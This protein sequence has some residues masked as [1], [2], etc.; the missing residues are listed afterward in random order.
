MT[1]LDALE[2]AKKLHAQRSREAARVD[3]R[4]VTA[5]TAP[6]APARRRRLEVASTP[7]VALSF[8]QLSIDPAVCL[9]HRVLLS[10]PQGTAHARA[11]DSYRI[12]RTRLRHRLSSDQFVTLGIVSAGPDEGKS[13]T[14]IN[15]ALAFA[16]EKR[17]NV[18]LLDLDLRNPSL[19]RYLGVSPAVDLSNCLA[20]AAK[21]E[22][23]FFSV[24]IE[25]LVL[26]GGL[27]SH[28]NSSELLGNT[29]LL[30]LL[31]YIKSMDPNALVI[32]DLPPL[33]QSA[34]SMVVAPHL[35][36]LALVISEGVTRRE[37]LSR[38]SELLSSLNV[39]GV[40]VNRSSEAI[41]D[42]YG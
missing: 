25:H 19:C 8:P 14:A 13:V 35:T 3:A 38:A 12:L 33:L 10:A 27:S 16:N 34:D 11:I 26:A 9:S 42:Y 41:E 15:L 18:F 20:R 36:T 21:P 40:I 29:V 17:R 22:D 6:T 24:G 2:K 37:H 32:A 7:A 39:A 28:D 4:E 1:I 23:V 30:E 31:D 5:P